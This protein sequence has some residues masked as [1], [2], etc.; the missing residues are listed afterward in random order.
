[1]LHAVPLFD[2]AVPVDRFREHL[3]GIYRLMETNN[4]QP[5]V[6]GHAGEAMLHLQPQ[7]NLG[8]VGDRQ[9]AFRLMDEYHKLVIGLG[10][11][12]SAEAGDGRLRTPYLEQMYG[13][14]LYALLQKVKQ[15]F[16]PYGTLNPGVKFGSSLDDVKS[17]I[18]ADYGVE[19]LYTHLPRS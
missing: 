9:K 14:E 8:Q 4:L 11:T 10:G 1:L 16:D 17:M 3:E 15:I 2:A 18:R 19:H 5:A 7:L 13:P 6:W 12:I